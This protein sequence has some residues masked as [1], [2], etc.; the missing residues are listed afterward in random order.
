MSRSRKP[1]V[2][3]ASSAFVLAGLSVIQIA[4][5]HAQNVPSEAQKVITPNSFGVRSLRDTPTREYQGLPLGGWM[6]YPSL[7]VAGTYDDNP[8][9]APSDRKGAAGTHLRPSFIADRDNGLHHTTVFTIGDFRIYPDLSTANTVNVEAGFNHTWEARKDLV[10][11][12]SG[13][14]SRRTDMYNTGQ[15]VNPFVLGGVTYRGTQASPQRYNQFIGSVGVQKS[16]DRLFIG[17]SSTA[18]ATTYDTLYTTTGALGQTYRNNLVTGVT[19]RLGYYATPLL[20]V[21]TEAGGNFRDFRDPTYNSEGYR[22]TGGIGTDRIGLIRGEIFAGYQSQFYFSGLFPSANSPVYGGKLYWYPT[23][24]WTIEAGLDETFQDS[25]LSTV[26]NTTGSAARATSANLRIGYKL[27]RS[28]SA[29][30]NGQ[31]TD[32]AYISGGRHDSRW[33]SGA[34]LNYEIL[35]NLNATFE[36]AFTRVF[37]NSDGAAFTRNVFTLGATYKY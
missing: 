29:T 7:L 12:A 32:I 31:Y 17:L 8:F 37:S 23:R 30:V 3:G 11:S 24:A 2:R 16:F 4:P 26:G 6:L 10:V 25:A 18:R 21:F 20:F 36:Y 13:E 33:N 1:F 19:G 27:A 14:Y 35:R 15:V 9:Q 22:F 34:T 28:W 5:S